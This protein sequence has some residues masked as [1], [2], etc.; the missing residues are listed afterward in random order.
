M[1]YKDKTSTKTPWVGQVKINGKKIKHRCQTRKEA[2]EWEAAQRQKTAGERSETHTISLLEWATAY[3]EFCEKKFVVNTFEEKKRAFRILFAGGVDPQLPVETLQPFVLLKHFQKQA[4]E[5]SG[6]AANKDRKNLSAAW[7]WGRNYL[8]IPFENPFQRTGKQGEVR[9]D[10]RIPTLAEFW[11]VFETTTELQDKR[12]LLC[13]LYSGARRA[14]LFQLRWQ[15]VDFINGRI[16]LYWKKNQLGTM[17]TAWL[18]MTDEAMDALREQH[19]STGKSKWVFVEPGT[20]HPYKYRLQWMRRLCKRAGVDRFGFHGIRHLCA[21]ILAGKGVPLVDI[22][23]HLRHDHLSTTERYIHK[24]KETRSVVNA[25]TGLK[26]AFSGEGPQEAPE[27]VDT[28][29]TTV[30]K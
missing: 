7:N 18:A 1:P 5:R 28:K 13:Y 3:L 16:R 4:G 15:D 23:D 12:M 20:D 29:L 2:I 30:S 22:Q 26:G 19:R 14:E 21:S 10:R 8:G 25:L 9:H 24:I 27:K 6:N 11:K 17:K